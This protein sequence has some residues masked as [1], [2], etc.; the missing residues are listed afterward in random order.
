MAA[1]VRHVLVAAVVAATALGWARRDA[2]PWQRPPTALAIVVTTPYVEWAD[3]LRRNETLSDVLTQAGITGADQHALVSATRALNARRLRAGTVFQFRRLRSMPAAD[4]LT[5]RVS[6][7]RRVWL[8]RSGARWIETV[9]M[10]P[11]QVTRLRVAGRI[12]SSLYETIDAA[13]DDSLLPP[14]ERQALAWAIADVYDWAVDFTR[15]VHPGDRYEVLLDRLESP[16]GER[17]FGR[18]WA[19]RVEAARV[20]NYAFY[21]EGDA[22][23]SGFYDDQGRSLRRAFLRTPLQFRRVSSSFGGR[24]HP[25]LKRWRSHEGIDY[26]AA[27]GTPVRATADGFV[28]SAG[29]AAGY[30]NLVELR[31]V[32]GIRT[33]YGHLSR[34][35]SGVGIGTRVHQGQTIGYVGSTGLSTGPHLHYEFLVNGRPT[36]PRRKDAGS[37]KPVP[38]E[39]RPAFAAERARLLAELDAS[40]PSVA[41]RDE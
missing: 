6:P 32:N 9:E 7:T 18:L 13:V 5:V 34:F 8:G 2:W 27:L 1:R 14:G 17:R 23:F 20:P 11:W 12:G 31:H 37:G 4:R 24:F 21:F 30:G 33:R 38:H 29:R 35:A 22:E 28:L 19:A 10:I 40:R 15:D 36:N 16:Q 25:I 39:Q 3:T 26:S 41:S